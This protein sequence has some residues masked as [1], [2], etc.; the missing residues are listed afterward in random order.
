M[1]GKPHFFIGQAAAYQNPAISSCAV[2]RSALQ[3]IFFKLITAV[4]FILAHSAS[5][6]QPGPSMITGE[7]TLGVYP[8]A[9]RVFVM[10]VLP[11]CCASP[12]HTVRLTVC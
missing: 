1:E 2:N 6:Q 12:E 8:G 7:Y 4:R 5:S 11:A 10:I 3:G 9:P